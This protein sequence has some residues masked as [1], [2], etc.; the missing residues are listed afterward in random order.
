MA[1]EEKIGALDVVPAI[2]GME[3]VHEGM[4]DGIDAQGEDLHLRGYLALARIRLP[5]F[6]AQVPD[7]KGYDR[8]PDQ[9]QGESRSTLPPKQVEKIPRARKLENDVEKRIH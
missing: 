6:V 7:H 9:R 4:A 1:L 8:S 2:E 3:P 5:A